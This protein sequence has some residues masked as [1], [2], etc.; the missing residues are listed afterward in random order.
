MNINYKKPFI[1]GEIGINH[2]GS[3]TLAKEIILL[4]KKSEFDAVK[5]QKRDLDV[6][7]PD[8]YKNKVR[9]TP[10][11][12]LKFNFFCKIIFLSKF[13]LVFRPVPTAVPPW[14]KKY[15]SSRAFSILS[16]HFFN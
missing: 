4:A 12:N 8:S 13:F 14:A 6:C 1:I 10:Y 16:M 7:I 3:V 2:N 15:I 11:L 9:E 5:I